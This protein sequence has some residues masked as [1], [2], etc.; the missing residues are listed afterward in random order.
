MSSSMTKEGF[1]TWVVLMHS[2]QRAWRRIC[3][4]TQS[5]QNGIKEF[6]RVEVIGQSAIACRRYE[7][8]FRYDPAR[9]QRRR[10]GTRTY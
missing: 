5:S 4:F 2:T 6:L 1:P 3:E 8:G 9:G 10:P 7:L